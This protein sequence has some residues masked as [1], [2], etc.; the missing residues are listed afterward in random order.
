MYPVEVHL[1]LSVL[2]T[3]PVFVAIIVDTTEREQAEEMIR[4]QDRLAAVGQMAA[5]IA[6]DFNNI[7]AVI[8]L[9]SELLLKSPRLGAKEQRQLQTVLHQANRAADLTGQVLDFSRQSV[10]EQKP[11]N[12]VPVLKELTKLVERTFPEH[13]KVGMVCK[14]ESCMVNADIT[15]V[16]QVIMN[17]A[18]N[19]RDAMPDGG[20]L[21]LEVDEILVQAGEPPPLSEMENGKWV[22]I[23]VSD[24]GKGMSAEV[25]SH[26]FEPFFTTKPRGRGTGLGLAQVYG[27]VKQ[28]DG[29][30]GV[31]SQ[32]GQGTT[33]T[34]YLPV[35]SEVQPATQLPVLEP[36]ITGRG[37]IILVVEDDAVTRAA[38]AEGLGSLNYKVLTAANGRDALAVLDEHRDKIALIIS[39][40]VMPE[41]GGMALLQALKQR[42]IRVPVVMLTGHPLGEALEALRAEGLREWLPK[43]PT[44]EKLARIV[45]LLL[46]EE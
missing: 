34:I 20:E 45:A 32:N 43:P 40:V 10:M 37:E 13:I 38:L 2:G 36:L 21:R 22:K 27:I 46:N 35:L 4:R 16:Q 23:V 18:L 28:H 31:E 42:G 17:L 8:T 11:V 6:H 26:L 1:Q 12:L 24:N 3:K 30:I 44:L 33:F 7:M 41:M 25:L 15:R 5:G 9:Y 14:L 39:D 19:A 29:H